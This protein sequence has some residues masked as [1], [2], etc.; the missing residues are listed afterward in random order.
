MLGKLEPHLSEPCF[1]RIPQLF[2]LLQIALSFVYFFLRNSYQLTQINR[3]PALS[4]QISR[5]AGEKLLI[6]WTF[7]FSESE[8]VEKQWSK[9]DIFLIKKYRKVRLHFCVD[10]CNFVTDVVSLPIW[11]N[12]SSFTPVLQLDLKQYFKWPIGRQSKVLLKVS[13]FCENLET[14]INRTLNYPY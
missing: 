6:N 7:Q 12:F 1:N 5:S 11:M 10:C 3:S 9:Q 2:E 8:N 4:N 13:F 14:L